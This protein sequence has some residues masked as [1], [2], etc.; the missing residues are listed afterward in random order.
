MLPIEW[1]PMRIFKRT[2]DVN[3]CDVDQLSL[4]SR[5]RSRLL[6]ILDLLAFSIKLL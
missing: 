6:E 2:V 4:V 1:A 3:L 5:C